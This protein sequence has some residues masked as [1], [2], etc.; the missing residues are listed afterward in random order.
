M[1]LFQ[2]PDIR[3]FW[4]EDTRFLSQFTPGKISTFKSYSKYPACYKDISFWKPDTFHSNDFCDQVRTVAGELV[5]NVDL[6]IPF[7]D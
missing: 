5:E 4:S 1:I 7:S 6:V 3:L 2:I